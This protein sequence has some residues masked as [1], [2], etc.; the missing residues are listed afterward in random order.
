[1]NK[2]GIFRISLD[3]LLEKNGI[4]FIAP[5]IEV[6]TNANKVCFPGENIFI[7]IPRRTGANLFLNQANN[8]NQSAKLIQKAHTQSKD[9]PNIKSNKTEK[10]GDFKTDEVVSV[11][12]PNGVSAKKSAHFSFKNSVLDSVSDNVLIVSSN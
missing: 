3:I 9:I 7:F 8:T 10:T 12:F 6:I 1:M 4:R 11:A 5:K 2:L